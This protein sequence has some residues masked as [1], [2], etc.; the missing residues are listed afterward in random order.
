ME[1]GVTIVMYHYVRDI[2]N[3]R[4]PNINGLEFDAFCRQ[5][6]YL[7]ENYNFIRSEQLINYFLGEESLPENS[8]WLTF[9]D[10]YKDHFKYVYPE[11]SKRKIQGTFFI[12]TLPIS[13]HLILDVNKIHFILAC[14]P[15]PEIIIDELE[16]IALSQGIKKSELMMLKRTYAKKSRYDNE[17]VVYIKKMLQHAL[18]LKVREEIINYLFSVFVTNDETAFAQDL[19]VNDKEIRTMHDGGMCIGNH[20]FSHKWLNKLDFKD[21]E[22]EIKKSLD[23]LRGIGCC[24]DNWIMCY[25]FGGFDNNS[26]K[27]LEMHDCALAVTTMIGNAQYRV[28]NKYKLPR[29]NTNDF[30]Q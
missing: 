21:Q 20:G 17:E 2:K 22:F 28:H 11:L 4:F 10:G 3:S 5:L 15:S 7:N 30:P 6:D 26:L 23:F 29:M 27:V 1:Q 14:S 25:P 13:D 18:P 9:D 12:P 19:Y 16:S 8:C 24:N